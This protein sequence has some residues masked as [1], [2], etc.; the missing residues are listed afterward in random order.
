MLVNS[1][2]PVHALSWD[3][4]ESAAKDLDLQLMKLEIRRSDELPE[5]IAHAADSQAGALFAMPDDPLLYNGRPLIVASAAKH[6]L[7]D[8]YWAS[9]FV[10]SGGLMSYGE[11]L[12]NSYRAGAAYVDK[13][14]KGASP[15]LLP[16]EQPTRFE[17]VI[18]MKT[19]KQ[20]GIVVPQALLLRA[21]RVIQ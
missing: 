21:D 12:R 5:A 19:A 11:N 20:L 8:F 17:L 4:L 13:I 9:E 15:A 16:V 14:K 7:P 10:E 3:R 1:N 18:N 2:N 6:R